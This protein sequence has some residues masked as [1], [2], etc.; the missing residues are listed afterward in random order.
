MHLCLN[1]YHVIRDCL[2]KSCIAISNSNA[3]SKL[4]WLF[5][6]FVF[7][8]SNGKCDL[9]Q[10]TIHFQPFHAAPFRSTLKFIWHFLRKRFAFICN[11]PFTNH[12][13]RRHSNSLQIIHFERISTTYDWKLQ[14]IVLFLFWIVVMVA[15]AFDVFLWWEN[16]CENA[17]GANIWRRFTSIDLIVFSR[18]R[19]N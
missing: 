19:N 9:A 4:N 18:L 6:A 12:P 11:I 16:V 2:E 5:D 3:N 13:M 17:S 15:V 7:S 14:S 10:G 8:K 1:P